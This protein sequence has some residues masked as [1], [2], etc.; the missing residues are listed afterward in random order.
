MKLGVEMNSEAHVS[1]YGKFLPKYL[2]QKHLVLANQINPMS[3]KV[4]GKGIS[5]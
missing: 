2:F 5:Q 4:S 1:V 3:A